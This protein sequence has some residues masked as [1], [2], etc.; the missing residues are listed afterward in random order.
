[1]TI[2]NYS[3]TDY[4]VTVFRGHVREDGRI[5]HGIRHDGQLEW[6]KP[7]AYHRHEALRKKRNAY[8][9]ARR[10]HWINKYKVSQGCSVCGAKD[11]HPFMLQL[12][13]IDPSLK[14]ANVPDLASGNLKRLMDEMR[15]CRVICFECHVEHTAEQN[16]K[17]D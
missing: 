2:T 11:I 10:K 15:K 6:R 17:G 13:H 5:L 12:D 4:N 7:D 16:R 8:K 9:R 3:V 1:M 14:V